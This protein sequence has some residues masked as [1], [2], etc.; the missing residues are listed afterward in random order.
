[1]SLAAEILGIWVVGVPAAVLAYAELGSRVA[2]RRLARRHD[3]APAPVVS[4]AA[5]HR[6]PSVPRDRRHKASLSA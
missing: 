2:Q 5:A 3:G 6:R 4:I 1:M